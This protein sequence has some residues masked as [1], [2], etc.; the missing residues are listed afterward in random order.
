M[1]Q[2]EVITTSKLREV[3]HE[4]PRA[5]L[6]EDLNLTPTSTM[7]MDM[8]GHNSSIKVTMGAIRATTET[9]SGE[10]MEETRLGMSS[11][12]SKTMVNNSSPTKATTTHH[13]NGEGHP[14]NREDKCSVETTT[15]RLV[16]GDI[17]MAWV[18]KWDLDLA[19]DAVHRKIILLRIMAPLEEECSSM[20]IAGRWEAHK[21]VP[22]LR[23]KSVS[24]FQYCS[25]THGRDR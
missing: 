11:S 14:R 22:H 13:S 4:M 3:L 16:Q 24:V 5:Q 23:V 15:V 1:R 25:S 8:K 18:G 19:E 9:A 6:H 21:E 2:R 10:R 12:M 20:T 7:A 17:A